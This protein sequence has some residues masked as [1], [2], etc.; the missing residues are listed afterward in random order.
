MICYESSTGRNKIYDK[1]GGLLR[2]FDG[3]HGI[4]A[5]LGVYSHVISRY[6][7]ITLHV[8]IDCLIIS[9]IITSFLLLMFVVLVLVSTIRLS[10][11]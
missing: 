8:I 7:N 3:E 5:E 9:V 4:A 1:L 11:S 2:N 6:C 10:R